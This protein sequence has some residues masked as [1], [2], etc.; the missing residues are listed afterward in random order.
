M[1]KDVQWFGDVQEMRESIGGFTRAK[2]DYE[3]KIIETDEK[4]IIPKEP[5]VPV[6]NVPIQPK[7]DEAVE[8]ESEQ[9]SKSPKKAAKKEVKADA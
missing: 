3:P 1:R 2:T 7:Q 5:V 8:E 4:E 9:T 6:E